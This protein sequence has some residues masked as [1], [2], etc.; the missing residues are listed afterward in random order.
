MR[1]NQLLQFQ[2]PACLQFIVSLSYP[3][4]RYFCYF[5][6]GSYLIMVVLWHY[7]LWQTELHT[8]VGYISTLGDFFTLGSLFVWFIFYNITFLAK[9]K[10]IPCKGRD[11][12]SCLVPLSHIHNHR[13]TSCPKCTAM[14][15]VVL[16]VNFCV[17]F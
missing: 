14:P 2:Y 17:K 1:R 10:S 9:K 7:F 4:T 3:K 15:Y 11:C 8:Y 16:K 5:L 6:W 12:I 13:T